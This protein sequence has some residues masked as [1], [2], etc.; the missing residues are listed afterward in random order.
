M[1][2][3]LLAA[4]FSG[5]VLGAFMMGVFGTRLARNT[6]AIEAMHGR[7]DGLIYALAHRGVIDINAMLHLSRREPRDNKDNPAAEPI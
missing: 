4:G 1:T 5:M 7:F 2:E 6:A 3:T